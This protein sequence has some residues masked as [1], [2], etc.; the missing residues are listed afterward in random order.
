MDRL[1][2]TFQST[3]LTTGPSDRKNK[4]AAFLEQKKNTALEAEANKDQEKIA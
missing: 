4:F 1:K 2:Q 3:E